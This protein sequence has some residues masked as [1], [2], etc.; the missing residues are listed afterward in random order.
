MPRFVTTMEW[1]RPRPWLRTPH[2]IAPVALFLPV[3]F[4]F[5]WPGDAL[6]AGT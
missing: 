2:F 4:L 3:A 6:A 1:T 5:S